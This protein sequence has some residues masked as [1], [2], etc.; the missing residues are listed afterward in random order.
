MFTA[1][2]FLFSLLFFF[3]MLSFAGLKK[4]TTIHLDLERNYHVFTSTKFKKNSNL[5]LVILLHPGG[6]DA[7]TMMS[8]TSMNEL[9]EKENFICAYPDA[10]KKYWNDGRDFDGIPSQLMQID[11]VGFILQMIDEIQKEYGIDKKRIFVTGAS[12]G[13]MMCYRLACEVPEK[14]KAI[15]PIIATMPENLVFK[16]NPKTP[17]SIITILGIQDPVV[18]YKGGDVKLDGVMLGR[19]MSAE[20]TLNFW[21]TANNCTKDSVETIKLDDTDKIDGITVTKYVYKN[22]QNTKTI[23]YYTMKGGGHAWPGSK[24]Y[25]PQKSIGF[26]CY[27][28][29]ASLE[30]WNF[31]KSLP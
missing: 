6:T 28:F 30:I 19:C 18:P 9:A 8:Y 27:D 1:R 17:V 12:S 3:S 13:A 10:F 29:H 24:P 16:C 4:Y 5:P 15:A 11:D 25:L 22:C 31:F 14:I 2:G 20:S 7:K 21:I 23:H 26:T